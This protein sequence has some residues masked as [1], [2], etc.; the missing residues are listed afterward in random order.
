MTGSLC[1]LVG[2]GQ[3]PVKLGVPADTKKL[4]E[5]IVSI[6]Y[7]EVDGQ[8]QFLNLE[9]PEARASNPQN[10]LVNS[11]KSGQLEGLSEHMDGILEQFQK[12]DEFV[13]PPHLDFLR[14][15]NLTPFA[16]YIFPF[17]YELNRK[18]IT[19]IWQG[20]MP[21]T[22]MK[23]KESS[24]SVCHNLDPRFTRNILGWHMTE[25]GVNMP[26][27]LRFM[28]FKIKQRAEINYFKQTLSSVDDGKFNFT[29]NVGASETDG[30]TTN[31]IPKYSYNWPY[32][33]CSIIEAGKVTMSVDLWQGSWGNNSETGMPIW[34]G[35][36][37]EGDES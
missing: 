37:P 32:D 22:A 34:E 25:N 31:A 14:N 30:E 16:M 15:E 7:V 24:R 1:N 33:F 20:V 2:F 23:V 21:E 19:D 36:I 35:K 6:P 29:F 11:Y 5:A 13:L 12:M 28:T 9:D 18:D 3:D 8:R 10:S 17:E 26:Q 27:N 4:K